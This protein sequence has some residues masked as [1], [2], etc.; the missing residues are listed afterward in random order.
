MDDDEVLKLISL[1]AEKRS[2]D[3]VVFIGSALLDTYYPEAVVTGESGDPG[4]EYVIALRRA[5]ASSQAAN[6]RSRGH[7]PPT[8]RRQ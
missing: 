5:L 8:T 3:A 2:W 7:G 6:Q 1:L 4:P